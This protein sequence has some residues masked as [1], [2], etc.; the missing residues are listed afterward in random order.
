MRQRGEAKVWSIEV[1]LDETADETQAE[2]V[3]QL[4]GLRHAGWGRARRN[5][6]DPDVPR[7]GE[8]L[9]AARALSDLAHRLLDAA[10]R[11]I[12]EFEGHAV[13]VHE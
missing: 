4:D 3:L 5:P 11:T 12:E 2:A 9:A 1:L 7:V 13:R 8:E 10:A 6:E